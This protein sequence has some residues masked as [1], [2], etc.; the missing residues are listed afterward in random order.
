T[1]PPS[2]RPPTATRIPFVLP[3]PEAPPLLIARRL[4]RGP[5]IGLLVAM[6]QAMILAISSGVGL[7]VG[8]SDEVDISPSGTS[9]TLAVI[10]FC[11][12]PFGLL[13]AVGAIQMLRLKAYRLARLSCLIACIPCQFF[14]FVTVVMGIWGLRRL[15]EPEVKFAFG[16]K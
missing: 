3:A 2:I 13:S 16:R 7:L 1:P 12:V 10:Q 4:V 15:K 5:A 6:I 8:P 9:I 11:F 14:W